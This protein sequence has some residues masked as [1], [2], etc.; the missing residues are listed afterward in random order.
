MEANSHITQP[1]RVYCDAIS[2]LAKL[3]WSCAQD[4]C[5]LQH[6]R[7][8]HGLETKCKTESALLLAI[9]TVRISL[10]GQLG[11]QASFQM[12]KTSNRGHTPVL[13]TPSGV[14]L[15]PHRSRSCETKLFKVLKKPEDLVTWL[16]DLA[17]N[18]QAEIASFKAKW[19][20]PAGGF[21]GAKA[22]YDEKMEWIGHLVDEYLNDPEA[23]FDY[24]RPDDETSVTKHI[25]FDTCTPQVL[26]NDVP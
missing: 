6:C 25:L 18:L 14:V 11:L 24:T 12:H 26:Q 4:G 22:P 5:A 13:D 15:I 8:Q 21:P 16:G 17:T 20:S 7:K 9:V 19:S 1:T 3:S 2:L 23:M 10:F